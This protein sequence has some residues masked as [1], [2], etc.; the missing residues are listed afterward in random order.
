MRRHGFS[1]VELSIVL[2]IL[3]L[4][5]G[6]I[7]AGQ[8]LIR[9]SELRSVGIGVQ[10]YTTAATAF[11]DKYFAPPGDF[12]GASGIWGLSTACAGTVANGTCNGDGNG[13]LSYATGASTTGEALQF[14]NQLSLAGMIEGVFTGITGT[15]GN[16][17]YIA[18]TN[19]PA[20]RIGGTGYTIEGLGSLNGDTWR[21]DGNY[22]NAIVFGM[23]QNSSNTPTEGP[24]LRPEEAWNIDTKMDDGSPASGTVMTQK[25]TGSWIS[26]VTTTSAS[27]TAYN[28][29]YTGL[30]CDLFFLRII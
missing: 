19:V 12:S 10:R 5:V 28:L 30:A 1:L 8:S 20:G 13:L 9:A 14:W 11:R 16:R 25:K 15:A 21:W 3:G 6:G 26:C 18:G 7:L 22:G 27:T 17:N 23:S 4:L 2:V 29:S 24:A